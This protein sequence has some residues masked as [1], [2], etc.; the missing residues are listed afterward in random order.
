MF[1]AIISTRELFFVLKYMKNN[2]FIINENKRY[3]KLMYRQ[4]SFLSICAV[5]VAQFKFLKPGETHAHETIN[6]QQTQSIVT[7]CNYT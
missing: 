6:Q 3:S 4:S 1:V 2:S 7:Q 5:R